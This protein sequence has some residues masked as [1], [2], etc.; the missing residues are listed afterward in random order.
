MI[1]INN[2]QPSLDLNVKNQ[3]PLYSLVE[4]YGNHKKPEKTHDK[5]HRKSHHKKHVKNIPVVIPYLMCLLF[6]V[7][8]P[9]VI[10]AVIF[11]TN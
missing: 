2:I 9:G 4:A 6:F 1:N 3:Y 8:I 10:L 5:S 11:N 7:I